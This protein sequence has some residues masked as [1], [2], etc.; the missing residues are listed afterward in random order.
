MNLPPRFQ[1]LLLRFNFGAEARINFY[2]QLSLLIDNGVSML[3]A[4]EEMRAAALDEG[5]GKSKGAQ[6]HSSDGMTYLID[7]LLHSIRSGSRFAVGIAQWVDSNE[8][9]IIA[10][11]EEAG[12]LSEAFERV[13]YQLRKRAEV[14]R[15]LL[16]KLGPQIGVLLATMGVMTFIGFY[17]T[18]MLTDMLPQEQWTGPTRRLIDQSLFFRHNLVLVALGLIGAGVGLSALLPRLRGRLRDWLDNAPEELTYI[19]PPLAIF[20]IYK[21]FVASDFLLNIATKVRQGIALEVALQRERDHATPYLDERL[22]HTLRG[23]HSGAQFGEALANAEHNFPDRRTIGALKIISGKNG[24]DVALE[25]YTRQWF[26][27]NVRAIEKKAN[28]IGLVIY[29]AAGYFVMTLSLGVI[30]IQSGATAAF[31]GP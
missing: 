11:G 17:L 2:Q 29:A 3:E 22:V 9:S 7:K 5:K 30:G 18:P 19:L 28:V 4:L 27:H 24:F 1:E 16:S 31:G 10:A 23:I 12:Q 21:M 20:P 13:A 6:A 15:T 8:A 26:D 14:R 25:Q